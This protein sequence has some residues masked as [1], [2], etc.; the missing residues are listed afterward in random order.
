MA[1][2]ETETRK[3]TDTLGVELGDLKV[4]GLNPDFPHQASGKCRRGALCD[5]NSETQWGLEDTELLFGV[6]VG[7]RMVGAQLKGLAMHSA[8]VGTV[9]QKGE[10]Q[11]EKR[12]ESRE[13][14]RL[15]ESLRSLGTRFCHG[16][17]FKV[18]SLGPDS[19]AGVE[20]G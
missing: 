12:Q 8:G 2:C 7:H 11:M 17:P 19:L 13:N 15:T 16:T 18:K 10:G 3:C 14:T 6:R 20:P 9:R 5:H 1:E 4:L